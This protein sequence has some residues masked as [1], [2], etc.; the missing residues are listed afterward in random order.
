[1]YAAEM[2][3]QA[4][5]ALIR[6]LHQDYAVQTHKTEIKKL[7]QLCKYNKSQQSIYLR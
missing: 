7:Q 2:Q 3:V 4:N 6:H 1:M 5:I